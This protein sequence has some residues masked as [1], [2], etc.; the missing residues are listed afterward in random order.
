M[1]LKMKGLYT[2]MEPT[3]QFIIEGKKQSAKK[4]YEQI[5]MHVY[6]YTGAALTLQKET[7]SS[8]HLGMKGRWK[9]VVM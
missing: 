4:K 5:D 7:V 8:L 2:D 1:Y 6:R 3:L 9:E